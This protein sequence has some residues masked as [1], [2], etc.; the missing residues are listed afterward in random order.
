MDNILRIAIC[1]DMPADA[2]TLRGCIEKSGVPAECA[3]FECGED[4]LAAFR[5]GRY[6]LIFM[7]IYMKGM[8]GIETAEAIRQA[9][10][11]AVIAFT[12]SSP[13]HT[14]ESYKLNALKYIDKPVN[15]K[16]VNDALSL[17]LMKKKNR[18]SI[19]ITAAGGVQTAV[20]LDTIIYF[21]HK[22]HAVRVNT[23][24]GEL[25]SSRLVTLNELEPR[26]PSPPFLRCHRS[27]LV[28]LDYVEAADKNINAFIMKNG[29]RAD[30]RR[31]GYATYKTELFRRRMRKAKGHEE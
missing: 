17:A 29:D 11:N 28:N 22:N 23:T 7:D 30:I 21:E 19:I 20:F 16:D 18:A 3:L 12:T 24:D 1:E 5:A 4:F 14:R 27:F 2:E 13:N 8:R 6:D 26:L 15:E 31:G 9:D 10:E 25:M